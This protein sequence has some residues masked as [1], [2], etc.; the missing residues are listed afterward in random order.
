MQ[1]RRGQ[2]EPHAR[3]RAARSA[4]ELASGQIAP[5]KGRA[6]FGLPQVPRGGDRRASAP[7][8]PGYPDFGPR[9]ASAAR[10]P[11]P[12]PG[13]RWRQ[14]SVTAPL[15]SFLC[16][17]PCQEGEALLHPKG[18]G[19]RP[20]AGSR[21]SPGRPARGRGRGTEGRRRGGG[22]DRVWEGRGA[23]PQQPLPPPSARLNFLYSPERYQLAAPRVL[24]RTPQRWTRRGVGE[25]LPQAARSSRRGSKLSGAASPTAIFPGT[26]ASGRGGCSC[27][28]GSC[29]CCCCSMA[30]PFSCAR[31]AT[32]LASLSP[33]PKLPT[34][35]G[36]R[37]A[38]AAA[39]AASS[40]QYPPIPLSPP[41][42]C[43]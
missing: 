1:E 27:G 41:T 23:A 43:G 24:P 19:P 3:Q 4:P 20:S 35:P 26:R 16:S 36:P 25:R 34:A 18:Q 17:A 8:S 21:Q 7:L 13:P 32:C 5:E 31:R 37:A 11:R 42:N 12:A 38:A 9:P 14:R 28:G 39:T 10:P 30:G 40:I 15:L 22:P 6:P 29:S 33:P 2:R